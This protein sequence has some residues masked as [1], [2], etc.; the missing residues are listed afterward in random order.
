[1]GHDEVERGSARHRRQR[2]RRLC[3]IHCTM[4]VSMSLSSKRASAL[5]AASS[6]DK[7]VPL[8][9]RSSSAPSSSTRVRLSSRVLC[10]R[11]RCRASM[12]SAS[13]WS[14]PIELDRQVRVVFEY[15]IAR[16]RIDEDP[17]VREH[18]ALASIVLVQVQFQEPERIVACTR[19]VARFPKSMGRSVATTI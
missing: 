19:P 14:D 6:L 4:P 1:M 18:L 15:Q 16:S 5:E 11:H 13:A 2:G 7:T 12:S 17:G 3:G 9:C 10:T 8:R